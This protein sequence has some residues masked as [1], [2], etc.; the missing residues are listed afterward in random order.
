MYGYEYFKNFL[1]EEGYKI[2]E[3][4]DRHFSFKFQGTIY[5][6]FKN[7]GPY[8]QVVVMCNTAE[9]DHDTLLEVCNR[10]NTERFVI[11]FMPLEQSTWVSYESCPNYATPTE[12]FQ[13]MLEELNVASDLLFQR[14]NE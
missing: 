9:Y 12:E 7:E 6:A 4:E 10:L 11:K 1:N 5:V 13:S 8:L 2:K 3:E 14:L